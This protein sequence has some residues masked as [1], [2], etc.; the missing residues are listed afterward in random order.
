MVESIET[1]TKKLK[2]NVRMFKQICTESKA[3]NVDKQIRTAPCPSVDGP[4]TNAIILAPEPG[5]HAPNKLA[6]I[7]SAVL[8]H[9]GAR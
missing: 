7:L 2:P 3:Q 8:V 5:K 1:M 9:L 6:A 4:P